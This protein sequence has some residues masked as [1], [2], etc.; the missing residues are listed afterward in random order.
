MKNKTFSGLSK[1]VKKEFPQDY[2]AIICKAE[3]ILKQIQ[4]ENENEP[5]AVAMHTKQIYSATAIYK[6]VAEY[7][8]SNEKAYSLISQYYE[9]AAYTA[10]KFLQA[11]FKIPYLYKCVP[12]MMSRIIRNSFGE[13]SG[14]RM[15]VVTNEKDK[16]HIDMLAC[17]Y[18]A[19]CKKYGCT[20][21]TTVFC[22]S[23]DISYGNMHPKAK[24][25]RTKTLGRGNDCCNFIL[26][27]EK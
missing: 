7:T 23:D 6:A 25:L 3:V 26:E 2:N 1:C 22:N 8:E 18:Y 24:W 13:K 16:C 19:N 17:P 21:L 4:S 15:N 12:N 14:F 10:Q 20:E 27:V 5:K 11:L 9:A